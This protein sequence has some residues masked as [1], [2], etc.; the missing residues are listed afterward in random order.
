MTHV[1][2]ITYEAMTKLHSWTLRQIAGNTSN[3]VCQRLSLAAIE[4]LAERKN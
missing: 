2:P 4:I 3:E 1:T